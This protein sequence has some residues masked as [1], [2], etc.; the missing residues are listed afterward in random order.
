MKKLVLFDV[1]GTLVEGKQYRECFREAIKKT[2]NFDMSLTNRAGC[3]DLFII[4]DEAKVHE[5]N[6]TLIFN[7]LE[8]FYKTFHEIL[9]ERLEKEPY[10]AVPG[11]VSLLDALSKRDDVI[12]GLL[13]GNIER[14]AYL[15]LE[16]AGLR[17]Y[18]SVGAFGNFSKD[19]NELV[20]YAIREAKTRLGE[21]ITKENV[22]I[23]GDSDKDVMCARNNKAV[24]VGVLAHSEAPQA[25]KEAK[26]YY[27]LDSLRNSEKFME[28]LDE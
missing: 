28:I 27:L 26:P 9:K 20:K 19:R 13:T 14:N 11:C 18:F 23:V 2:W 16:S 22:I 7:S 25:L 4:Y 10:Q 15:K 21:D 12:L 8:E 6:D 1:D 24:S 3:T 5:L 17:K